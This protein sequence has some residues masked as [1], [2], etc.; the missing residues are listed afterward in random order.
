MPIWETKELAQ[1][2][3]PNAM[4]KAMPEVDEKK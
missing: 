2:G 4:N 3:I 1:I